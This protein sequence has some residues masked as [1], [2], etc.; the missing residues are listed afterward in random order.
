MAAKKATA[1]KPKRKSGKKADLAQAVID[2]AFRLAALQGWNASTMSDIAGEAGISLQELRALHGSKLGILAA[3]LRRTDEIVLAGTDPSIGEEPVKD[4][5]FDLLIRRLDAMQPQ[6]EAIAAIALDLRRDPRALA[7]FMAGPFR[8]SMRWMLDAARIEP[9]GPLAG[10]QE[11]GLGLVYLN[12]L[13]VWLNDD[14]EDLSA[15]MAALDKALGRVD[16]LV[17]ML[18][19]GPRLPWRKAADE[20][21]DETADEA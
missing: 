7:C 16:D 19:R 3:A 14:S 6:R 2:A 11:K 17:A 13:R 15:T 9:W 10:L 21:V 5:L 4:R 8:T 1:T 20:F 18:R 12:V